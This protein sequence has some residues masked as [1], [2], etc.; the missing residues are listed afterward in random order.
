MRL[1]PDDRVLTRAEW[2]EI[3]HRLART[4]GITPPGD[5]RAC[6]W[7]ALAAGPRR[8]HLLASLVRED[9]TRARL[10]YRLPAHLLSESR[11]IAR[12]LGLQAPGGT[13]DGPQRGRGSAIA[14]PAQAT[15]LHRLTEESSGPL[16][17]VRRLVEQAAYQVA[18]LPDGQGGDTGRR[19]EWVAR[20]LYAVQEDLQATAS[21]L[22]Q[23]AQ[24]QP[25]ASPVPVTAPAVPAHR[26]R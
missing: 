23:S 21:G 17:N 1:H 4:T 26:S 15:L 10:P 3:A 5:E 12:D 22:G 14:G 7:I 18:G 9:G 2:S 6:R 11:R 20:R 25:V 19:L 16:A 8:V 24:R 13:A